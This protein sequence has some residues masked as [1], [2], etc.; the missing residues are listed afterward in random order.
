MKSLQQMINEQI[1]N[2]KKETIAVDGFDEPIV[3]LELTGKL[4][5]QW[6]SYCVEFDA[7]RKRS[8]SAAKQTF[9]LRA[10]LIGMSLCESDGSRPFNDRNGYEKLSSLPSNVIDRLFDDCQRL[11]HLGRYF[12]D[13][14]GN[15]DAGRSEDS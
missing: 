2:L 7:V 1:G 10:V 14:M 3:L 4:L 12:Q 15:S 5:E 9:A 8:A 11:N 6:E 13:T